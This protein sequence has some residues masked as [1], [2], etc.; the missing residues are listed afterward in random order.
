M[1]D[2]DA[3]ME[4]PAKTCYEVGAVQVSGARYTNSLLITVSVLSDIFTQI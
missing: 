4:T 2:D 1:P 3:I